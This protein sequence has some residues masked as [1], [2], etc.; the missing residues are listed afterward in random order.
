MRLPQILLLTVLFLSPAFCSAQSKSDPYAEAVR[1]AEAK[2]VG[3]MEASVPA[4]SANDLQRHLDILCSDEFEGRLTG[5]KGGYM[6]GAYAATCFEEIGLVPGG[7]KEG[8]FQPFPYTGGFIVPEKG[9]MASIDL[10]GGIYEDLKMR[11]NYAPLTFSQNKKVPF[12]DIVFAGYGI[13]VDGYDSYEDL[14]VAGKWVMVFRGVPSENDGGMGEQGPLIAKAST[15]DEM[16]A[17]GVIF[18]KGGN[19]RIPAELTQFNSVGQKGRILPSISIR[20]SV[21]DML[22][23]DR[24]IEEVFAE[25][26]SGK[27]VAGFPLEPSLEASFLVREQDLVGRNV[28]GILPAGDKPAGPVV[29]VCAHID[30]LG[31][32]QQGGSR[33]KGNQRRRLHPGADD[34]ASGTAALFEVA[35]HLVALKAEGKLELKRDIA[36]IAF[37]GEEMGLWGS[38]FYVEEL[39]K[40]GTLTNDVYACLNLDMIGRL[41]EEFTMTGLATS[42][43]WNA[44]LDTVEAPDGLSVKRRN[45][46]P[47]GDSMPFA[48][49]GVPALFGIT[50]MHDDYHT[51]ADTVEKLNVP[52]LALICSYLAHTTVAIANHQGAIT[53][54]KPKRQSRPK[55]VI[56]LVP[57]D[58][59]AGGVLVK[60][61]S[62]D[63][64]AA[65][66][67]LQENDVITAMNGKKIKDVEG[68]FEVL[69]TLK[70]DEEVPLDVRRGKESLKLKLT[71]RARR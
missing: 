37:S 1:S 12:T 15:A 22:L 39:K 23:G 8:W 4:P 13:T 29:V 49:N 65:Q 40:A 7:D 67:G 55:V 41:K 18:V 9:N 31:N 63:F 2:A 11:G 34:N 52:G 60:S 43:D 62:E 68:L 56:G 21:A 19:K 10:G 58:A 45:N 32:G 57:E 42:T 47:G 27:A 33:A 44:V 20:N 35:Q 66:A 30:H 46:A 3:A 48:N 24:D 28:I 61:V 38:R 53:Y 36:F 70:A 51:P 69:R 50:G 16:G 25:Y 5:V 14:D 59:D 17:I 26:D 6:A 54:S 64:P 71:P